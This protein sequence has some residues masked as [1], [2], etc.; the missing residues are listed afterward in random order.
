MRSSRRT[1]CSF[2]D[3]HL[4]VLLAV[5]ITTGGHV[6]LAQTDVTDTTDVIIEVSGGEPGRSA[7]CRLTISAPPDRI[8]CA[9]APDF[10]AAE[11][12]PGKARVRGTCPP[13]R[14]SVTRSDGKPL[15][16]AYPLGTTTVLWK[17]WDGHGNTAEASQKIT[18]VAASLSTDSNNDSVIDATDRAIEDEPSKPGNIVIATTLDR[19]GTGIPGYASG[20]NRF[21]SNPP[22]LP[23]AFRT[24]ILTV[25]DHV[26][27]NRARVRLR[28][29]AADPSLIT[30]EAPAGRLPVYKSGSRAPIRIWTADHNTQRRVEPVTST[31]RGDF[32]PANTSI[33]ITK[34]F[35]T[36]RT[37]RLFVEG[38]NECP[39]GAA[40][41]VLELDPDGNG[42]FCPMNAVRF[43]VAQV[44]I[45]YT[46]VSGLTM[47]VREPRVD[48]IRPGIE[49]DGI[50]CDWQEGVPDGAMLLMRVHVSKIL[51]DLWTEPDSGRTLTFG[52]IPRDTGR[53]ASL[54]EN[55]FEGKF[56]TLDDGFVPDARHRLAAVG[57]ALPGERD[58][59][60]DLW[61]LDARFYRPPNEFDMSSPL[62]PAKER[63][64]PLAIQ[65]AHR[66]GL[67]LEGTKPNSIYL[68]RP[69]LV[70]VHGI[71]SSA[72]MWHPPGVPNSFANRFD[73]GPNNFGFNCVDFRVDHSGVNPN[74]PHEG[75]T[76]GMGP[77]PDMYRFVA[78]K[79]SDACKSFREG[80][81]GQGIG[82]PGPRGKRYAV[83]KADVVC[84][85]YGGI[86]TRWYVEQA[87][88]KPGQEFEQRRDVR[89]LITLGTP[90]KGSPLANMVCE[91]YRSSLI[92]EA[93][94][95]LLGPGTRWLTMRELLD[96]LEKQGLL[97]NKLPPAGN[98]PRHCYEEF[99]INSERLARLNARPFHNH[100][101]YA[102]VVGTSQRLK[103]LRDPF[104]G[105][106]PFWSP[107]TRSSY[108]YFPW[109]YHFHQGP[110]ATDSIVPV[111]S[112]E[113][114]TPSHNAY[115]PVT[116]EGMDL[117]PAVQST[118][119]AWLNGADPASG[120]LQ[121]LPLGAAQR[122][123]Y[124]NTPPVSDRNAY[125]GSKIGPDNMSTGSGLRR[126]AI[127]KAELSPN[128]PYTAIYGTAP[129]E[130]GPKKVVLTG[131]IQL[132][133]VGSQRFVI[134]SHERGY[135]N[136]L[137]DLGIVTRADYNLDPN[138]LVG[139]G[140]DD[141]VTYEIDIGRIGRTRARTLT[142]PS[143]T[144]TFVPGGNH[145][146]SYQMD[147]IP[148][149]RSP[150]T[151]VTLPN[152]VLP[153][154][155]K[156]GPNNLT[157]TL[158]GA[159]ECENAG[160][161]SQMVTVQLYAKNRFRDDK[162][163]EVTFRQTHPPGV[164]NG[165]LIP[166][167]FVTNL[168]ID[169]SGRLAGNSGWTRNMPASVFQMLIMSAFNPF[170]RPES[171]TV[172]VP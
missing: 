66:G 76:H 35:G 124:K 10:T 39:P 28:Y 71:N 69:P 24:L 133:D 93:S 74:R 147:K 46:D 169:A 89:K 19:V 140:P 152:Y 43:T 65:M 97:P 56:H 70:L 112:A 67:V 42:T 49:P 6:V 105:F 50:A 1:S 85:S 82:S 63:K 4:I 15:L 27:L 8:V 80:H 142:G 77:V 120:R 88:E 23:C 38:V 26:D 95:G 151:A 13:L 78:S 87:G 139:A 55:G 153:P 29:E 17:T 90:H 62:N 158:R 108:S 100:V 48:R 32:V 98:R 129:D 130:V 59:L 51:Y 53:F 122:A 156:G 2:F 79:I 7:G 118:V 127:V 45:T 73:R 168:T 9:S 18:V 145:L 25:S 116:H 11:V 30:R 132:K 150:A 143:G 81:Y 58:T 33:P 111:W 57:V 12:D 128:D 64:L 110:G 109:I 131:M 113:L 163:E 16:S 31:P 165:L 159:V 5:F 14:G 101:G 52:Q 172:P 141:Y 164:W 115:L 119:R 75:R 170:Y 167:K 21:G 96:V 106:A 47:G 40:R 107:A 83:Q 44:R 92:A 148:D 104:I 155:E 123:A 134:E 117:D 103:S 99:S 149:G 86:L 135:N 37:T 126:R 22:Y 161:G 171:D 61:V 146:V 41:V 125:D 154:P 162:L 68:T 60:T 34:L 84:H 72:S 3:R 144:S 91:V 157:L 166:Y 136:T 102:A 137:H 94:A 20:I 54:P 160:T 121:P 114:G 138:D 36:T